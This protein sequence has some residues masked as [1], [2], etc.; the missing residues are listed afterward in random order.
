M[1]YLFELKYSNFP[2]FID[3]LKNFSI[4]NGIKIEEQTSDQL[5]FKWDNTFLGLSFKVNIYALDDERSFF[6]DYEFG[7]FI[8]FVLFLALVLLVVFWSNLLKF[9]G[10]WLGVSVGLFLVEKKM[11]VRNVTKFFQAIDKA[12]Q[13]ASD[14][15]RPGLK[16]QAENLVCPACGEILTPYDE[17]CP[18]CGLYLGPV[19]KKQPASRTGLYDKRLEY[20]YKV[21]KKQKK[22]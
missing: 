2:S 11:I 5:T 14:D 1:A 20:H 13:Q 7:S 10:W 9:L 8:G 17:Y 19:W 16:V 3:A 18:A 22:D 15:E 4:K 6:W 12:K 21:F